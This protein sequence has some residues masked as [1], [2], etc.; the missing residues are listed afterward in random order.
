MSRIRC[1]LLVVLHPTLYGPH[2]A[3]HQVGQRFPAEQRGFGA[4]AVSSAQMNTGEQFCI[5][6]N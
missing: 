2:R 3:E 1:V 4:V 6:G 5:A